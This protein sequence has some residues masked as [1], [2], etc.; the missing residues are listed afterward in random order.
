MSTHS[1]EHD[2]HEWASDCSEF[3]EYLLKVRALLPVAL[4]GFSVC[5]ASACQKE[6]PETAGAAEDKTADEADGSS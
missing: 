1:S 2:G 3:E 5:A 6:E 4:R